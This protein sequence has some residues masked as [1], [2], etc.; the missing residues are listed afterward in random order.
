ME[1]LACGWSA[2][3]W[4]ALH[5]DNIEQ[6]SFLGAFYRAL[7]WVGM[8]YI[9]TEKSSFSCTGFKQNGRPLCNLAVFSVIQWFLCARCPSA[10]A[11]HVSWGGLHSDGCHLCQGHCWALVAGGVCQLITASVI[12]EYIKSWCDLVV[13]VISELQWR[14]PDVFRKLF[15][16]INW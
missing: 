10:A 11:W 4:V 14:T 12:A 7:L 16:F 9:I 8:I 1:Y 3:Y 5:K 6:A 2:G 15:Y 13:F